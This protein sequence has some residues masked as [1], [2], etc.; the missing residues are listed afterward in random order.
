MASC[1]GSSSSSGIES[2]DSDSDGRN[3]ADMET[4]SDG[5]CSSN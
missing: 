1:S 3:G 4:D 5:Y 2:I